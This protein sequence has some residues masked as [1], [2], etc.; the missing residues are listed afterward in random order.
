MKLYI[1]PIFQ[2]VITSTKDILCFW[3]SRGGAKSES[4]ARCIIALCLTKKGFRAFCARQTQDNKDT[5][6]ILIFQDIIN[7]TQG[8]KEK[9]KIFKDKIEFSN[10]SIIFFVGLNERTMDKAKGIKANIYWFDEAHALDRVTYRTLVPSVREKDSKV[11]ISFNPR[12]EFDFVVSEFLKNPAPNVEVIQVDYSTNPFF[13][14]KLER[15]RVADKTTL[16]YAEYKW[17]WE[18]GFQPMLENAIFDETALKGFVVEYDY[19]H[20]YFTRTI[21]GIDPATTSKDYNNESGVVVVGL[22]RDGEAV[23]IEDASGHLK[24]S[25]LAKRVSELYRKYLCDAV[26]VEVNQGGDYLKHTLLGADSTLRVIEV[27]AKQDKIKRMLPIANEVYLG[28]V[29]GIRQQSEK[30]LEQFMKF[31]TNGYLGAKGESPDRAEAFAWACFELLG[32]NEYATQGTIFK[33]N[34][35]SANI[36]GIISNQN[37][38]FVFFEGSDYGL[39]VFDLYDDGDY[40]FM[41][42]HALKGEIINLKEDIE[43]ANLT[44]YSLYANDVGIEEALAELDCDSIDLYD[45]PALPL[46]ELSLKTLPMLKSSVNVIE[47]E[48]YQFNGISRNWLLYDLLNF[49]KENGE[50]FSPIVRAFCSA[51]LEIRG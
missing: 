8:L 15:Q 24:P 32:I 22:N 23:L 35:L 45:N 31:T 42:K 39:V 12:Y 26:V 2:R 34:L 10:G 41:F 7:N 36:G 4:I 48:N 21:I 3:G 28:R 47:C 37:I 44:L 30:V 51:I 1:P 20:S 17:I 9:C 27:R 38:G 5:T 25:D 6:L 11:I 43:R 18:N 40:R 33:K 49:D 13:S 50:T 14:E 46:E 19:S 16:P 29:K